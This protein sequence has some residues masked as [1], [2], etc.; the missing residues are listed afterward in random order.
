MSKRQ[1]RERHA[2]RA[3]QTVADQISIT[4]ASLTAPI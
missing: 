2:Q 4:S 3:A 1:Q